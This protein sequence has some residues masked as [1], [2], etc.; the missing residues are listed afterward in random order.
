M[1]VRR[2]HGSTGAGGAR[3]AGNDTLRPGHQGPAYL[4]GATWCP[5]SRLVVPRSIPVII[6]GL[7]IGVMC[8]VGI[9]CAKPIK[10]RTSPQLYKF[11]T[12]G[13]LLYTAVKMWFA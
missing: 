6:H 9:Q 5:T 12:W 2:R 7:Q 11:F 3:G 10:D 4:P 13:V 8:L 1:R